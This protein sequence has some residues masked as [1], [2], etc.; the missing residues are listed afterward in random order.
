M[1]ERSRWG[2]Q[3]GAIEQELRAESVA[4][5]RQNA[6]DVRRYVKSFAAIARRH[7]VSRELV[8]Q[9]ASDAGILSMYQMR[10]TMQVAATVTPRDVAQRY[11]VGEKWVREV[12]RQESADHSSHQRWLWRGW[13]D[14][15]LQPVLR[16]LQDGSPENGNLSEWD[17]TIS[18]KNQITLPVAALRKLNIRA[19]ERLRAVIKGRS[20]QLLPH[21]ISW[22]DY[23]AGIAAG[24]YGQTPENVETYLRESRGDWEPLDG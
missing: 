6:G 7:G 13:D 9:I 11:G 16:R 24:L 14:P 1:R 17:V 23:Y 4:V 20:I 21:P 8:R 18:S 19:G 5:R 3:S 22:V 2:K 12:A 15:N 10:S